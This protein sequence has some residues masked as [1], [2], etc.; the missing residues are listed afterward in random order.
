MMIVA[1]KS[2]HISWISFSRSIK[3]GAKANTITPPLYNN[4]VSDQINYCPT[5]G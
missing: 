1:T 2:I 4:T 5:A 3:G